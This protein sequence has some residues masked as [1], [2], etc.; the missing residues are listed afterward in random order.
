M[1]S[2]CLVCK[3]K[4]VYANSFCS[5]NCLRYFKSREK[6]K[7]SSKKLCIECKEPNDN[8]SIFCSVKCHKHFE[9]RV[10]KG[11]FSNVL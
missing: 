1:S 9:R 7:S 4:V 6:S 2:E 5:V 10:R 3:V 8:F 11:A